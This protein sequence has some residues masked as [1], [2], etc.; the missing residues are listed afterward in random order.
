MPAA[1]ETDRVNHPSRRRFLSAALAVVGGGMAVGAVAA[2]AEPPAA[3]AP[4]DAPPVSQGY[5][6]SGHVQA[7]YRAASF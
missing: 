4:A 1:N 7:Y 3:A 2:V 6:E 5:R